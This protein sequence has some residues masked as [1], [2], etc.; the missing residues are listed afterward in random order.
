MNLKVKMITLLMI[1]IISNL[2]SHA[3]AQPYP[4]S[5]D[6]VVCQYSNQPYG[7]EWNETSTYEWS[8]IPVTGGNGTI[9]TGVTPNLITVYWESI[10]T[11]NLQ[12]IET[13]EAG[14]SVTVTITI[15]INL[16]PVPVITGADI[17][18]SGDTEAYEVVLNSG[19]IY[20]WTVSG[21][22]IESGQGS[23][24]VTI[25]WTGPT[26]GILTV[27]ETAGTCS[28]ETSKTVE[29]NPLPATLTIFHN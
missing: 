23:N 1:V 15:T 21:G 25:T 3:T 9:T 12:L 5:G 14:C 22:T 26:P 10:G 16:T 11:C 28:A 18:C 27:T 6:Q 20:E 17:V 29:I 19:N 24:Q 4:N 2:A 7:V 8:I 13:N